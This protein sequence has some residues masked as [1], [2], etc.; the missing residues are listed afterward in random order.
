[1]MRRKRRNKYYKNSGNN[2]GSYLVLALMCLLLLNLGFLG[3]KFTNIIM[4]YPAF[5]I[6]NFFQEIAIPILKVME[7]KDIDIDIEKLEVDEEDENSFKSED[8]IITDMQEY[9]NLIIVKDSLGK[10]ATQNIPPPLNIKKIKVDKENPY[11]MIYHTHATE[12]YKP[13]KTDAFHTE[14]NKMNV[15][16]VGETM[17]KVLQAKEHN[18]VDIK[19]HHDR[20]SYNKSYSR[21][22]QTIKKALNDNN[23]L[24]FFFDIHRD[25]IDP[26]ASYYERALKRSK[27][28]ING[29]DVAT[30]SLVL[31]PDTPNYEEVLAFAKYIKAVSDTLYPGLFK[32]I[33]VKPVGKYNLYISEYA[34][35]LEIGSNLNTIEEGNESAKLVGEIL[36]LVI[37]S[38]IE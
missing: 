9:E 14:D 33:I 22:S 17:T 26:G 8:F 20:P 32:D 10:E 30:F 2:K 27:V 23:N 4:D 38:I 24:K 36:D 1:M 18:V 25:G 37:K 5:N 28:E 21:S 35:L 19:T 34:A 15:T 11:I 13:F 31:G 29:V 6:K 12:G 16:S 3:I 7:D